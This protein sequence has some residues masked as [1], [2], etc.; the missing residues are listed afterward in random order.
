MISF[1]VV[2]PRTARLDSVSPDWM[3]WITQPAGIG[4]VQPVMALVGSAV[5]VSV[6]TGVLLGRGVFVEG[7]ASVIVSVGVLLGEGVLLGVLLA[8]GVV[9]AVGV[10][11]HGGR[12][13]RRRG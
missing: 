12:T 7:R 1:T 10:V 5:C 9:V 8:V 2:L 3:R 13:G 11:R 6:G 4:T